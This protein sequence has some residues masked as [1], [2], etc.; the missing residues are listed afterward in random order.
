M[1]GKSASLSG[2]E[3]EIWQRINCFVTIRPLLHQLTGLCQANV[4]YIYIYIL[5]HILAHMLNHQRNSTLELHTI[6]ETVAFR[7]V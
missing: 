6:S 4:I 2:A 7:A 1:A 3:E 5:T